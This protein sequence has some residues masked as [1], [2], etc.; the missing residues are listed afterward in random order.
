MKSFAGF[1]I[2]SLSNIPNMLKKTQQIALPVV[3][4]IHFG[5]PGAFVLAGATVVLLRADDKLK[6]KNT[7]KQ[8][9][10]KPKNS[11]KK[12]KIEK[13]FIRRKSKRRVMATIPY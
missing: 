12:K 5:N 2:I 1:K 4:T 3:G 6:K 13:C 9:N 10:Q 7:D 8:K 11:K